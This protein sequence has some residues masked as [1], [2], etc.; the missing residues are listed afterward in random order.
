MAEHLSKAMDHYQQSTTNGKA[1]VFDFQ[2]IAMILLPKLLADH[3]PGER[4]LK[5]LSARAESLAG[6]R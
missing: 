5:Y 3:Y 2:G 6:L 4:S 1:F